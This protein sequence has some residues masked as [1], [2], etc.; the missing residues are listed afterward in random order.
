MNKWFNSKNDLQRIIDELHIQAIGNGYIDLICPKENA[1][2]FIDEMDKLHIKIIGITWWCHVTEGHEPCG[3]GGP[4]NKF[5]PGW[6]SEIPLTDLIRFES[7]KELRQYLLKEY[8]AS[9]EYKECHMP[10]FWL[11]D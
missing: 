7:N 9:K 11:E 5:G 6:Y 3:T 1:G 10:A 8:P 4:K 2:K